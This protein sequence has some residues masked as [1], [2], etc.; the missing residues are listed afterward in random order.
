MYSWTQKSLHMYSNYSE[1][2]TSQVVNCYIGNNSRAVLTLAT[3]LGA[4]SQNGVASQ[5]I[6]CLLGGFDAGILLRPDLLVSAE[7]IKC[8]HGCSVEFFAREDLRFF[9]YLGYSIF[10]AKIIIL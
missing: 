1:V 10:E 7:N 8:E 9:S 2:V 3:C 5:R 4:L 6:N